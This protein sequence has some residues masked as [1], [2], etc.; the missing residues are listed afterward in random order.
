VAW[1]VDPLVISTTARVSF[2]ADAD[3][4]GRLLPPRYSTAANKP[5]PKWQPYPSAS[6]PSIGSENVKRTNVPIRS[7]SDARDHANGICGNELGAA[8][9]DGWCAPLA[10]AVRPLIHLQALAGLR[11]H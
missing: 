8:D 7:N 11:A 2:R 1:A 10:N 9:G 3:E 5:R 4:I 6:G